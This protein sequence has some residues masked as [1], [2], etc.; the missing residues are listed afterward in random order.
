VAAR[1]TTKATT[2]PERQTARSFVHQH[3]SSADLA[4]LVATLRLLYTD[5]Y[6]IG[7][8]AATVM[9]ERLGVQA[10]V[11]L[12]GRVSWTDWRPGNL[13]TARLLE[14]GGDTPGLAGL[15]H[16]AEVTIKS[17]RDGYLNRLGDT[18]AAG[19]ERGAS[20]DELARDLRDLLT[21]DRAT[22]IAQTETAR[23]MTVA[24]ME[25]YRANQVAGKAVIT[26][27]DERVCEFCASN[28][29]AGPIPLGDSFPS[30]EPPTH[31][32]CRCAIVPFLASEMGMTGEPVPVGAE[33]LEE[34]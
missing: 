4:A 20:V 8:H 25:T 24:A 15:L 7:G 18:L 22:M 19:V 13:E 21:V 5:G 31:P 23:A 16:Q 11:I 33:E 26:A 30:G 14:A 2:T 32:L 6:L 10:T 34:G 12:A 3:L 17:V 9:L 28:E 1:V 27:E 29:A